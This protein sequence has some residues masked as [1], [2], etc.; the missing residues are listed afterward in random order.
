VVV[1]VVVPI[2]L[3]SLEVLVVVPDVMITR[4]LDQEEQEIHLL[5]SLLK[6]MLEEIIMLVDPMELLAV[7]AEVVVLAVQEHLCQVQ[8]LVAQER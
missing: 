4:L 3:V 2:K 5:Q 1:P 7:V 6:E 8:I